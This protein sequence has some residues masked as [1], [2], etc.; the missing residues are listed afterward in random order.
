LPLLSSLFPDLA[1]LT[2]ST[3]TQQTTTQQPV[4][5]AI[6]IQ[7][8]AVFN[9]VAFACGSSYPGI[10]TQRTAVTPT[11]LRLF[12]QDVQLIRSDGTAVDME[13]DVREPWQSARV[14]LLDFE[15]GKGEC[16]SGNSSRNTRITGTVPEG[17][18]IGIRFSNAVPSELNHKTPS[19]AGAPL[20]SFPE[21]AQSDSA[22]FRFAS[23]GV[24][25]S[26]T[27]GGLGNALVQITERECTGD[28][29]WGGVSCAI[30]NRNQISLDGF[31]PRRNVIV[32]DVARLFDQVDLTQEN[33]CE[34][35]Q[36][37]A[38]PALL[39]GLGLDGVS[40]TALDTQ[41]VYSVELEQTTS[42]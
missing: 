35:D 23:I 5:T 6:A 36:L 38:C 4:S 13:L 1:S 7:Y 28:P 42:P 16:S 21:L 15:D 41:R 19:K 31:D 8:R 37:Q 24:K 39:P 34:S 30:P 29:S 26:D 10:G 12:V 14:A 3:T 27:V 33:A 9:D 17:D 2:G 32:I 22:G 11:D 25:Q 20:S 40:G 18:Y